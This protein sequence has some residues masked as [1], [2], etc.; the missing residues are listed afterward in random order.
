MPPIFFLLS[1]K[2]VTYLTA[3]PISLPVKSN[4]F[5]SLSPILMSGFFSKSLPKFLI[6]VMWYTVF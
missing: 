4:A 2:L 1:K 5:L 6:Y 3:L